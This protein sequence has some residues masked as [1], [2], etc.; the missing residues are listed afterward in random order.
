MKEYAVLA[1]DH[2]KVDVL[3]KVMGTAKFAADYR[4]PNML[5]GG[6]FRSKV[7]HAI[8]K[9]L[10]MEKARALPGVACVLDHTDR[11]SVM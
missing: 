6:V 10:D 8:V 2:I 9:K 7:P 11:K 1:K 5:Y 3:E 4:M